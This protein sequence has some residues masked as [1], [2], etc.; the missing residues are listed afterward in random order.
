[1]TS[2]AIGDDSPLYFEDIPLEQVFRSTGRTITEAD[3]VAFAGLSATTTPCTSTRTT[4][5]RPRSAAAW[6][7]VCSFFRS[8]PG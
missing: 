8:P 3:I 5:P 2:M 7:T 1:M 4:R 6:P